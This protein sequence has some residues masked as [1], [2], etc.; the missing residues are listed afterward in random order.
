VAGARALILSHELSDATVIFENP[1][2]MLAA[3]QT[4]HV[5]NGSADID[6]RLS[7][8]LSSGGVR[9][10]GAGTLELTAESYASGIFTVSEGRLLVSGSG[11]LFNAVQVSIEGGVF[12]YR[13]TAVFNRDVVLDG[14]AFRYNSSQAFAG[15]LEFV[16][17]SIG[18]VG[19]LSGTQIT[20]A[21]GRSVAPGN[22]IGTLLTGGETWEDGGIYEWEIGNWNGVTPGADWDL[23]SIS[24]MLT[25]TAGSSTPFVIDL[26]EY[27]LTGFVEEDR[28]FVIATA[29]GGITGFEAGKFTLSADGFT[30][31]AGEWSIAQDGNNLLLNYTAVPE[32]HPTILVLLGLIGWL[33]R[34]GSFRSTEAS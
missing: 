21:D 32:P 4:I 26:Q 19:N 34:K 3:Q 15:T 29:S 24:E 9:K 23:L 28:S 13:S 1:I 33:L 27:G 18:G 22:S 25:I 14:G 11:R 6:A 16:Q 30:D 12:D 2:N 10:T 20:L 7:G 5:N 8:A 17:G 31:G